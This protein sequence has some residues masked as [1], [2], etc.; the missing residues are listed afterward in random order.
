V[1]RF[2]TCCGPILAAIVAVLDVAT[3]TNYLYLA[4]KPRTASILDYLGPWPVY[5]IASESLMLLIFSLMELP[6]RSTGYRRRQSPRV[7]NP[8]PDNTSSLLG[9]RIPIAKS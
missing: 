5:L 3:G 2:S 4:A 9:I 6:F 7:N 8:F 1:T